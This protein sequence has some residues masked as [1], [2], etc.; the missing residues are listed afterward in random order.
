VKKNFFGIE[1]PTSNKETNNGTEDDI[2]D[3]SPKE[4]TNDECLQACSK[5][6]S[7]G[8]NSSSSDTVAD[9]LCIKQ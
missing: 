5:T 4:Y 1:G 8:E 6:E 2:K 3:A 7:E 9:H